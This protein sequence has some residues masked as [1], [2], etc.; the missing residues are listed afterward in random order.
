MFFKPKKNALGMTSAEMKEYN[1]K[2][3]K[4]RAQYRKRNPSKGLLQY[5][6]ASIIKELGSLQ[7]VP[8]DLLNTI[9]NV[10]YDDCERNVL[11]IASHERVITMSY[12][13]KLLGIDKMIND[14]DPLEISILLT[15]YIATT[16]TNLEM[17]ITLLKDLNEIERECSK[18]SNEYKFGMDLIIAVIKFDIEAKVFKKAKKLANLNEPLV[19]TEILNLYKMVENVDMPIINNEFFKETMYDCIEYYSNN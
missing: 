10:F 3:R 16:K 13:F 8:N 14:N 9:A 6:K 12:M 4:F 5:T 1:L 2:M 11:N 19:D 15:N 7:D 18:N 17:A